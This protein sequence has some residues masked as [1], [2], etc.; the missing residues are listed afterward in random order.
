MKRRIRLYISKEEA[1]ILQDILFTYVLREHMRTSYFVT[2]EE[3]T[4]SDREVEVCEGL[5]QELKR[6][7][8]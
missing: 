2:D 8:K 5:G 4:R 6:M 3:K 7:L 1:K